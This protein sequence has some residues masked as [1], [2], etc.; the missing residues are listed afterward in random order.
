G[1]LAWS[2]KN[3]QEAER[4]YAEALR[5]EP[6]NQAVAMNLATIHLSST[7]AALAAAGRTALEQMT[8]NV[9]LRVPALRLLETEAIARKSFATALTYARK[10]LESPQP[11]ISDRIDYLQIARAANSSD[12]DSY[13]SDLKRG[14]ATNAVQAFAVGQWM[15]GAENPT[16]ALRWL[17]SLPAPIQTN[18]MVPVLIANCLGD[19]NDWNALLAWVNPQDWNDL[20]FYRLALVSLARSQLKQEGAAK[21]AW[22]KAERLATQRL[23][24][25]SR[26]A[27]LSRTWGW[28]AEWVHVLSKINTEFPGEKWAS[29]LLLAQYHQDGNTRALADLL[30]KCYASNPSDQMLKNDLANV[31]LLRKSELEKA[32]RM[33]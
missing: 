7:N 6:T 9:D 17:Q 20:N 29:G 12:F 23:D 26:L 10:I 5:L 3:A 27:Q 25:L 22:Q 14:A 2:L 16:N 32:H 13:L 19:L 24:R 30:S 1:A 15:V 21:A 18:Q 33:A 11:A 8:T 4:H 31:F 28:K